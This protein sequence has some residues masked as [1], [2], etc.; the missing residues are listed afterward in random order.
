MFQVGLQDDGVGGFQWMTLEVTWIQTALGR[1]ST[2][3]V[4]G[5]AEVRLTSATYGN[6]VWMGTVDNTNGGET[7]SMTG[8]RRWSTPTC[9]IPWRTCQNFSLASLTT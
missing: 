3:T 6:T 5:T 9:S 8:L 1:V 2:N 4:L 7:V